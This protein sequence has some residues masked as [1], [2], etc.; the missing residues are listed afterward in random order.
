MK[1]NKTKLFIV[2]CVCVHVLRLALGA[3]CMSVSP[4]QPHQDPVETCHG[5]GSDVVF[6]AMGTGALC[7]LMPNINLCPN[8]RV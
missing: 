1:P 3:T 6:F 4:W 2:L 8:L 5:T 7:V